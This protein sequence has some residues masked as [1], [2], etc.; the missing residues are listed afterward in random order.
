MSDQ[1]EIIASEPH[2]ILGTLDELLRRPMAG[3]VRARSGAPVGPWALRVCA[4]SIVCCALYGA[5]SGFFQGGAQV[6]VAAIKAPL[7]IVLSAALCIPS[8]YV[9][10]T[11]GGAPLTRE[12]FVVT[13]AGFFGLLGLIL[14]ALL[15]IEWLFSVSS[16][17]LAFVVW[18]HLMLWGLAVAFGGR[19]LRAAL[20]ELSRGAV[21]LWLMLFCVVSFQVTTFV[22]PT[23][24][25]APAGAVF[26]DGKLFF[27]DHFLRV[28]D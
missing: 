14:I 11:L 4:G 8:L 12:R 19:F 22:R 2:G 17:S 5:A 15:P 27:I 6:A 23:L 9:F 24:W 16:R 20:P 10:S 25:R 28:I 18:L 26:E 3:F 13:L 1:I 7:I 21:F